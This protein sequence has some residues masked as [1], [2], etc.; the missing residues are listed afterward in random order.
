MRTD[1]AEPSGP[2]LTRGV[3]VDGLFDGHML[4]G[5]VGEEAVLVARRGDEFFAIGLG[6][7]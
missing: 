7:W 4:A 6:R 3:S 2:D 5:H 1:R